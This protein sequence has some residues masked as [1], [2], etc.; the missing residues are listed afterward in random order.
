MI[1]T[2]P[3][4]NHAKQPQCSEKNLHIKKYLPS[5]H[6]KKQ[7]FQINTSYLPFLT[8]KKNFLINA[9]VSVQRKNIKNILHIYLFQNEFIYQSSLINNNLPLFFWKC[10]RANFP[11]KVNDKNEK[12]LKPWR[13]LAWTP[14]LASDSLNM[15]QLSIQGRELTWW[16]G[17]DLNLISY[18]ASCIIIVGGTIMSA[19]I[20]YSELRPDTQE[21]IKLLTLGDHRSPELPFGMATIHMVEVLLALLAP[22]GV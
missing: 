13:P 16:S 20:H 15:S 2:I 12:T 14:P 4:E 18:Q 17:L 9:K 11:T 5:T 21:D 8:T 1:A 3:T 7:H 22:L 6:G 19:K 10:K